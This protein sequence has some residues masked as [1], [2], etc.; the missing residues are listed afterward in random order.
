MLCSTN[1]INPQLQTISTDSVLTLQNALDVQWFQRFQEAPA[2]GSSF[3]CMLK[4]QKWPRFLN[5]QPHVQSKARSCSTY[6]L[7]AQLVEQIWKSQHH[8]F[9]CHLSHSLATSLPI[10]LGFPCMCYVCR[11][12]SSAQMEVS[13]F[14]SD[15]LQEEWQ[16]EGY[17]NSPQPLPLVSVRETERRLSNGPRSSGKL[18]WATS[19]ARE[20]TRGHIYI[21]SFCTHAT[22]PR[23]SRSILHTHT[24]ACRTGRSDY[25]GKRKKRHSAFL[26][27]EIHCPDRKPRYCSQKD[28]MYSSARCFSLCSR[29][30]YLRICPENIL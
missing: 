13:R 24:P 25:Q 1:T 22:K 6:S 7:A 11:W 20:E 8:V 17:H 14:P 9:T 21:Q 10:T 5:I 3:T 29:Q 18:P 16:G 23:V 2:L 4:Q 12:L 30:R 26:P 19:P 28:Y 15:G 27:G